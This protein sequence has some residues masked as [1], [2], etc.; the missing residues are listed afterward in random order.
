M[1]LCSMWSQRPAGSRGLV[2]VVAGQASDTGSR[3]VQGFLGPGLRRAL[4]HF[5]LL[6]LAEASHEVRSRDWEMS[7]PLQEEN[8]HY[9]SAKTED[10]VKSEPLA[11]CSQSAAVV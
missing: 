3:G 9:H 10:T 2:Q 6:L 5:C 1:F 8:P 11:L 7:P 4:R